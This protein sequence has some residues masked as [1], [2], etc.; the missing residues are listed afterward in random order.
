[1]SMSVPD[2]PTQQISELV[3]D[4]NTTGFVCLPNYVQHDDL[5]RMQDF[6]TSAVSKSGNQYVDFRGP[7]TVYGSGLEILARTPQF[8]R[9]MYGLY[10]QGTGKVAP[11]E[12]FYQVLRCLTGSEAQ[13]HSLIYHYDSYV[14]TALIPIHIPSEGCAGDLLIYPNTRKIRN[15]YL[16]NVLD[17]VLLNNPVTQWVLR[18]R[19]NTRMLSPMRIK[20]VPGHLYLFWGYRSIHTN[21]PCDPDKVRATAL[22]HY[23]NPHP[24]T[25]RQTVQKALRSLKGKN[26]N[27]SS[28]PFNP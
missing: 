18:A 10:E 25:I 3:H 23:A 9:L 13:K 14:V 5:R 26:R 17:K 22:F 12:A 19:R 24:R 11:G 28:T 7:D 27:F 8:E 21:E 20:L 1:M 15:A 6:V 16:L 4:L 2:I